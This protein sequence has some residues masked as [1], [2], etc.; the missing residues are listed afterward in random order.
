MEQQQT[1][2]FNTIL[3]SEWMPMEK[4]RTGTDF[5]KQECDVQRC[6][7]YRGIKPMSHVIMLGNSCGSLVKKRVDNQ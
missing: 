3:E 2:V 1:R 7:Y 5:R 4:K 6:S